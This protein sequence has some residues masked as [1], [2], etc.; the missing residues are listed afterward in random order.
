MRFNRLTKALL[1]VFLATAIF[2]CKKKDDVKEFTAEDAKIELR[3][4][5]Q[6]LMTDV[7]NIFMEPSVQSINFLAV[8][9]DFDF[10][11]FS[12]NK[13]IQHPVPTY[14][15]YF[16][17]I[18]QSL[19]QQEHFKSTTDEIDLGIFVYNFEHDY[20]E[21]VEPSQTKLQFSFPADEVAYANQENNAVLEVSNLEFATIT[22]T[23]TYFDDWSGEWVTETFDQEVPTKFNQTL[24]INGITTMTTNYNASFDNTAMPTAL[25]LNLAMAP[26]SFETSLTG[27]GSS[28]RT[29]SS[30]KLNSTALLGHDLN[31]KYTSD[32][33]FIEQISGNFFT[34]P[35]KVDGSVNVANLE[36][37]M[38]EY[39]ET[40]SYD[41]NELNAQ[42]EIEL[43][44]IGENAK[45]GDIQFR[46]YTDP[47]YGYKEL[48][49]AIV[50]TDGT[51]EFLENLFEMDFKYSKVR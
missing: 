19:A 21:M 46:E 35:L 34:D 22:I 5:S 13:L 51:F 30:L 24:A 44:H 17:R 18:K 37:L 25:N 50:Y 41:L 3:E 31:L 7:Q 36:V 28:Y 9:L 8:L 48:T 32:R 10:G 39:E 42:M 27:S 4:A 33:E 16:S 49:L 11:E 26:Y 38:N 45:L 2:S 20:F 43:L 1:L 23:E 40:G 14:P 12:V 15:K 29:A 47:V 6:K